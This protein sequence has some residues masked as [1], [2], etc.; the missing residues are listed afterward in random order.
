MC[1]VSFVLWI[2][3]A[4][5]TAASPAR[6]KVARGPRE[7]SSSTLVT[8]A[9]MICLIRLPLR[10]R[11]S[12]MAIRREREQRSLLH[13][14]L[15]LNY[16]IALIHFDLLLL[17]K[18]ISPV[19]GREDFCPLPLP[20]SVFSRISPLDADMEDAGIYVERRKKQWMLNR[21]N[22]DASRICIVNDQC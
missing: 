1:P 17:R 3:K 4:A 2:V 9:V 18:R 19:R 6:E 7:P 16:W 14:W 5:V 11:R 21:I 13:H 22:F 20:V 12:S 8:L 15:G 10:R